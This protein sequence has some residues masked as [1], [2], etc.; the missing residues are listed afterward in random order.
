MDNVKHKHFPY[1]ANDKILK[2]AEILNRTLT[3]K[4]HFCIR[5]ATLKISNLGFDDTMKLWK[6]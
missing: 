2:F 1:R 3:Y 5:K 4:S 6:L